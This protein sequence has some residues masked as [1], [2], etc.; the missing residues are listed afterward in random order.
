MAY[1]VNAL[2]FVVSV[3]ALTGVR[4]PFQAPRPKDGETR[5]LQA[6]A[7]GLRYVWQERSIRLL[8][9]LNGVHRLCFAPLMLTMAFQ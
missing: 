1:G 7:E 4:T 2:T 8:M 3:L 5:L 6:I 9:M